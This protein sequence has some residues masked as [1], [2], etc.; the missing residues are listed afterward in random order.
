MKKTQWM[1]YT[2]RA[3]FDQLAARFSI[4]PVL[5]RI[6]INRGVAPDEIGTYLHG[7][8]ADLPDP[9]RM[10]DLDRAAEI[11][12]RKRREGKPVRVIG[13]YDIDGICSTYILTV[14]FRTA[15][16]RAD[17]D[18]PDRIRDG[19]GLNVNLIRKAYDDGIDTIVTCDNGIAAVDE[20]R[21]AKELGMTVIV[22]DHHEVAHDENG[23]EKLPPADAVADPKQEACGYPFAGICGAV[24]AWKLVQVLYRKCGIPE[25]RWK[26]FLPFA[27]IATVG[28]VMPLREEN[29]IIVKE[30]LK[31]IASCR[32]A[33]LRRLA[34]LCA[35]DPAAVTAYQIGYVIGPCL[36]AGGRL[37]SAK[38][39]LEML[40][41]EDPEKAEQAAIHLKEL[42]DERKAMTARGV[43]EARLQVESAP[44]DQ[45]VLVVYLPDCHES[46]AGIIAGRLR[47]EYY[48]P[49]IVLT[50]S[51]SEDWIK[52]SGRSIE[53]YHMFRALEGVSDLLVRFGG[54]PMAAG[55]TMKRENE[56]VFRKRLNDAAE[57]TEKDLTE[58]IWIDAAMPFSYISEDLVRSL[59]LLEPCGQGNERPMFAQRNVRIRSLRVVGRNRNVVRLSVT[60]EDGFTIDAVAFTDGDRFLEELGDR[61]VFDILYYPSINEYMGRS[62]LQIVIRGWKFPA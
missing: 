50:D 16:I 8:L 28:D 42:N 62:S 46:V 6:M 1:L 25:E 59:S 29:R 44:Q 43:E 11:L 45:K 33:G 5:V 17:Y 48:R 51:A 15:G 23:A 7:T 39:G 30:G 52:G 27:A 24:V 61:R 38:I 55:L 58:K 32:N 13:D 3:D 31:A 40:L 37:E 35:L 36:N 41:E 34:E 2:K 20:I 56:A 54:H 22:T 10:K 60:G 4:S 53:G 12:L 9:G 26:E 21:A 19:Y 47:E 14:G 18:I 49:S 57:L